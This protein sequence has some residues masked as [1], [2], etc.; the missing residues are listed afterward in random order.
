VSDQTTAG[1]SLSSR[2]VFSLAGAA[3]GIVLS[4]AGLG[5]IWVVVGAVVSLV[6]FGEVYLR[7]VTR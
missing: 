1:S 5:G 6:V 4:Q 3:T 7:F 2:L